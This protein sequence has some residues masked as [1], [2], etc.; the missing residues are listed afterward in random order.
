MPAL[1]LRKFF[2]DFFFVQSRSWLSIVLGIASSVIL[3][4]A[5]GPSGRG[6]LALSMLI[7]SLLST[8][9]NLGVSPANVYHISTKKFT[10]QTVI[11]CSLQLWLLLSIL[12]IAIGVLCIVVWG[13]TW[14]PN[15]P[16]P[17]LYAC[18]ALFP[19]ILLNSFLTS[20]LQ[21]Q[22]RFKEYNIATLV[23]PVL[24]LMLIFIFLWI[25]NL[26]V[27]GAISSQAIGCFVA[28]VIG[29]FLLGRAMWVKEDKEQVSKCRQKTI[30][31]GF[32]VHLS[33]IMAFVNYRA[34]MFILNLFMAPSFV[35][36]YT[37]AV[38]LAEKLWLLSQGIST[39]LLPKLGEL[40]ENEK[41][42]R[43][44]TP[45]IARWVLVITFTGSVILWFM[46]PYIILFLYGE[47]FIGAVNPF[48]ILLVGITLGASSRVLAND[49][50]ARGKP[51]FNFYSSIVIV[52]MNIVLNILLIPRYGMTGAAI[53]TSTA[54]SVN[55][56]IKIFLYKYLS[57]CNLR[58][59]F[60]PNNLD[61]RAFNFLMGR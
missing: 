8:F 22:Q 15:I 26:G 50:A 11:R 51:E 27:M 32:R 48:R 12:G 39:V 60:M 24:Q 17:Y 16:Q 40:H 25:L 41:K 20:I 33:N 6:V 4:R 3:A 19:L 5:L 1:S 18:L 47:D 34:D 7:P 21:G 53:A 42:R 31:Y 61:S 43:E 30:G 57:Q 29:S 36:I 52:T 9:L 49:L 28:L 54:Y 56:F 46:I 38:G 58:Q 2:T 45:F 14:F 35:G 23:L 44:L 59:I 10:S 13:N 55:F 37:M